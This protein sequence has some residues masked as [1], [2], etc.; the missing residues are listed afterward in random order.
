MTPGAIRR[1]ASSRNMTVVYERLFG[2]GDSRDVTGYHKGYVTAILK[3]LNFLVS[4]FSLGRIKPTLCQF[5]M[6][7]RK[8]T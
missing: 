7:L 5:M 2:Y 3:I 4:V 8:E 6:I 1:F